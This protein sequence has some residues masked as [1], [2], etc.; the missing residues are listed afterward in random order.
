VL[1]IHQS[2]GRA[3]LKRPSRRSIE[4]APIGLTGPNTARDRPGAP[5]PREKRIAETA[6][7][8]VTRGPVA[9]EG[10]RRP[11]RCLGSSY[12]QG[13][14]R[15]A[16]ELDQASI[17]QRGDQGD[18][19]REDDPRGGPAAHLAK[20][21]CA[22]ARA[23]AVP[24]RRSFRPGLQVAPRQ[25]GRPDVAPRPWGANIQSST[26]WAKSA[27]VFRSHIAG[28]SPSAMRIA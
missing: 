9:A 28:S 11:G 5:G 20:L 21:S 15:A 6:S 10:P 26:T 25:R 16:R 13:D 2:P 12:D 24:P 7:V 3:D 14:R 19:D 8:G 1:P 23:R 4:D 18:D 27:W 22:L 17:W